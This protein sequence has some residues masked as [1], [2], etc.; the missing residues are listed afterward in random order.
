MPETLTA[1]HARV[2]GF[3]HESLPRTGC[4]VTRE[5]LRDK[6][7]PEGALR[8]FHG[9]TVIW[10]L[11]EDAKRALS[12]HQALLYRRAGSCLAEPL[13][14]AAFHITRTT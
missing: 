10:E 13:D 11:A 8:P 14:P 4:L 7:S 5:S 9:N 12:R 1:F 3:T 6:V 2:D